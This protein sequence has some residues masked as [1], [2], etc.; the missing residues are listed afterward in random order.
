MGRTLGTLPDKGR[1]PQS[2]SRALRESAF[3]VGGDSRSYGR[4]FPLIL[5]YPAFFE[6]KLLK[7]EDIGYIIDK[8]ELLE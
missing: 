7:K 5:K 8:K 1:S 2:K 3:A 4:L 6:E